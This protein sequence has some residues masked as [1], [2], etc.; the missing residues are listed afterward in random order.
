MST[1]GVGAFDANTDDYCEE[2]RCRLDTSWSSMS[3]FERQMC[4]EACS[5][6]PENILNNFT[7]DEFVIDKIW[8][9]E[10]LLKLIK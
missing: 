3:D 6:G 9:K 8:Q 7:Y 1:Q 4:Q 2:L 10:V 5:T